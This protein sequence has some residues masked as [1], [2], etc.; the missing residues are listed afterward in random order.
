MDRGEGIRSSWD[1]SHCA[2]WCRAS[3]FGK[4]GDSRG[5]TL[6]HVISKGKICRDKLLFAPCG[7]EPLSDAVGLER[8]WIRKRSGSP[9]GKLERPSEWI[10]WG[11]GSLSAVK[12]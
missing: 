12:F 1:L 3:R 7:Y 8:C 11:I 9:R 10:T 5:Q 4:T 2:A 6:D